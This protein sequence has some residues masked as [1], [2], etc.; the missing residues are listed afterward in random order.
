MAVARPN[1][2]VVISFLVGGD[3]YETEMTR[4]DIVHLA[5]HKAMPAE[6][7]VGHRTT[8]RT[9]NGDEVFADNFIGDLDDHYGTT[10]LVTS[11][12][13]IAGAPGPWKNLGFDHL[14]ITVADRP[15]ARDFLN[16]VLKMQIMRDDP[17][18]TV[19]STGHTALFLF[20]AGP[21]APLS[22]GAA[23]SFHHIGFVVDNLEAAYAHLLEHKDR[24][25]SDFTLLERDER[26]S[27]YFFYKNGSVTFM[28]QFSEIKPGWRGYP[29]ETDPEFSRWLYDYSSRPYGVQFD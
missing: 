12:E 9:A 25:S 15:A 3:R 27:L 19:M 11:V 8:F 24:L 5:M 10:E 28:I 7:T 29:P 22:S 21:N 18:L 14:A 6:L 16:D 1:E 26:W 20:D 23:S 4:A 13:P 17:H 2:S